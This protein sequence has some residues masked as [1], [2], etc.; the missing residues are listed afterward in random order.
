MRQRQHA[1]PHAGQLLT[2]LG[3]DDGDRHQLASALLQRQLGGLRLGR[4]LAPPHLVC[5]AALVDDAGL[6]ALT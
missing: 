3:R 6:L 4:D 5:G 2:D 1:G